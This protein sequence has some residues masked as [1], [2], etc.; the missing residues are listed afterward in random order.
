MSEIKKRW[1]PRSFSKERISRA[2]I[3]HILEAARY[4]PSC[5]NE[6]PWRFL[7]ADTEHNLTKMRSILYEKNQ[8][9]ANNAPVLVLICAEKTFA[10]NGKDNYWH[11]FDAGTSW[12]FLSLEAHRMG[13]I[14]HAMGGFSRKKTREAFQIPENLDIITVV[15]IGKMGDPS[16]LPEDLS[17]EEFP[18]MR[19]ELEELLL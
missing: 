2:D 8:I 11:M 6:Q 12:G 4:A 18:K 13:L 9:W 3:Y 14:T 1:S 19:K 5:F 15:A 16:M 7:I 10:E 17:K